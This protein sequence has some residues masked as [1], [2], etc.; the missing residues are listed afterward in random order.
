MSKYWNARS[1]T[2]RKFRSSRALKQDR[3]QQSQEPWEVKQG[4]IARKFKFW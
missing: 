3:S 1:K 4:K 2:T